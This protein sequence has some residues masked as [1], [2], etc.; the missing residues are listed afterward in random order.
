MD[1]Q[2]VQILEKVDECK[3]VADRSRCSNLMVLRPFHRQNG[4]AA[5][6][7]L[8]SVGPS[9]ALSL[10]FPMFWGPRTLS[11]YACAAK[12]PEAKFRANGLEGKL[13]LS[14]RRRGTFKEGI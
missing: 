14:G 9:D 8:C 4:K 3:R 1:K 6:S 5:I 12:S 2:N 7:D 13:R 10:R 11:H